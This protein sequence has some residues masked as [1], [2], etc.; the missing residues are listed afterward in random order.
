MPARA[1]FK[2]VLFL[3]LASAFGT[4]ESAVTAQPLSL[5]DRLAGNTLRITNRNGVLLLQL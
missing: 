2:T 5:R 1:A 3:F 4:V